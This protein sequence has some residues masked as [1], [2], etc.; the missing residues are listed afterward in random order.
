MKYR[1]KYILSVALV[2]A[3]LIQCVS[4]LSVQE[5][6]AADGI[7]ITQMGSDSLGQSYSSSGVSDANIA[8]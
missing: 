6:Y 5:V 3:T 1:I 7:T 4:G 8:T 2:L